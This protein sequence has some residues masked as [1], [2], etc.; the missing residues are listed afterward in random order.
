M[1]T[2]ESSDD[3]TRADGDALVIPLP[4]R[5]DEGRFA[6]GLHVAE[7]GVPT[8]ETYTVVQKIV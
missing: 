1:T 4:K 7:E 2:C 6:D 3:E 8:E 5:G